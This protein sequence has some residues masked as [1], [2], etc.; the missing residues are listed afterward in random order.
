MTWEHVP[1]EG[2]K[3][4]KIVLIG[5]APGQMEAI[6]KRPFVGAAGDLLDSILESVGIRRDECYITNLVKERPPKND[7]SKVSRKHLEE[8]TRALIEELKE[9]NANVVVPM[10]AKS[11]N[12]LTGKDGISKWAGSIISGLTGKTIPTIHPAAIL[13]RWNL[14]PLV[15]LDFARIREESYSP[16]VNLPEVN[17]ITNPSYEQIFDLCKEAENAE[18]LSFD[19]EVHGWAPSCIGFSTKVNEGF[20]IPFRKY[21]KPCWSTEEEMAI[22]GAV[23]NLLT[24]TKPRKIAQNVMFDA[25]VLYAMLGI[26]VENFWMDTMLAHHAVYPELPKGLDTLCRIYTRHPYYKDTKDFGGSEALWKYN[27]LDACITLE[28]AFELEREL[29]EFGTWDFYQT[30]IQPLIWPLASMQMRGLKVDTEKRKKAKEEEKKAVEGIEKQLRDVAENPDLNLNSP[31]QLSE[32]LYETCNFPPQTKRGSSKRTTD[33]DALEKLSRKFPD[34]KIL[35]SILEHRRRK[36]LLSTYLSIPIDKDNRIRCSFNIAGTETGR[37][38]SSKSVFGSGGNLQNVPKGIAREV[39]IPDEGYCFMASD[40]KQAEARVVA[41]LAQDENYLSAFQSGEDV[42]T[43]VAEML[44]S[45]S[46]KR[47]LA[48]TVVHACNYDMGARTFAIT[49]RKHG[50]DINTKEAE[51]L[52]ERFHATFPGVRKNFHRNVKRKLKKNRTLITPLGRKR[53]FFGRWDHSLIKEGYAY[54]PQSTVG[55]AMNEGISRFYYSNPK[56]VQLLLN[57]H[58]EIFFQFRED[59][60]P[61]KDIFPIVK[62]C[63]EFPID[64]NGIEIVIPIDF[65]VGNNWQE[66]S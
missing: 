52:I 2:P 23:N 57:I 44:F 25:Y 61:E 47:Y 9:I 42:H 45:D 48:K 1:P 39:I 24:S 19:L 21:G 50:I 4:A 63:F 54:I 3:D 6:K 49:A 66:V 29:K 51:E 30:H 18:Y 43:N 26:H 5:E 20:C 59:L 28:C 58:D 65:T 56:G 35:S 8:S 40:Y 34:S 32:F 11:F 64:V 12:A 22:W 41:A 13:Y 14:K 36:K 31:K 37:L 38:A 10:G 53:T 60:D 62:R 33:R 15:Q 27:I 7:F 55:D 17:F 16:E 46:S